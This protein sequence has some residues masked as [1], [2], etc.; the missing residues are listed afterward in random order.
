MANIIDPVEIHELAKSKGWW[1]TNRGIPESL[2]LVHSE[3]SEALES[4]RNGSIDN[5]GEELADAVIRIFDLAVAFDVDILS[6]IETKHNKNK[7]RTY[8]HG[9]KIA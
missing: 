7:L 2:C 1:D 4:Y 5:F 3:I 8:R 9:N 6:A